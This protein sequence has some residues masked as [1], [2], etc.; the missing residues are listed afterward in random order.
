MSCLRELPMWTEQLPLG[1]VEAYVWLDG[2]ELAAEQ[3]GNR[4]SRLTCWLGSVEGCLFYFFVIFIS[5]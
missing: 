1:S 3:T 2:M 4:S 5:F